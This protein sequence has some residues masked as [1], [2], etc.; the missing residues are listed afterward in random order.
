MVDSRLVAA[1]FGLQV[2]AIRNEKQGE[3]VSLELAVQ[4]ALAVRESFKAGR[5]KPLSWRIK[6]LNQLEKLLIENT[7]SI[8]AALHQDLGKSESESLLTE[9][10]VVLGEISLFRKSL[11]TW[12][13]PQKIKPGI[14]LWPA[15]AYT[16]FE[17]LGPICIISPW[18]YPLNLSLMPL[19][20]AIAAG[21]TAVIKPS[22][23]SAATAA[24]LEELIPQYLDQRAIRVVTGG[25]EI[26]QQLLTQPWGRIFYTGGEKVG[27]I[28]ATAAAQTLTPITLEL[29]GKSPVFVDESCNLKIAARRIVFGKFMNAGQTCVAPDYLLVSEKAY[30][31]LLQNLQVAIKKMYGADPLNN[32]NYGKIVSERHFTR[33]EETLGQALKMGAKLVY[34]GQ[35]DRQNRRIAP[36]IITDL[37]EQTRLMEEEIFGPILPIIKVTGARQA[38]DFINA[39]PQPLALYVFTANL[40]SWQAF[41]Y[42]T[43]SGALVRDMTVAQLSAP[44]LP[45]GGVGESGMG[46]YHGYR[47][48]QEFSHQK[49]VVEKSLRPDTLS[50]AYPPA[51]A[52]KNLILRHLLK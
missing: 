40:R 6:Q 18:N 26:T 21:N 49:S 10:N 4:G 12:L 20:G 22:E 38:I 46:A 52:L 51:T 48:L 42:Q 44:E 27:K 28:V 39:R 8:C 33:L 11:S 47:S 14:S 45:F 23:I 7:A 29:G 25:A 32:P 43:S 1:N 3:S 34:G 17:P 35:T 41:Q 31:E 13:K 2:I 36:A 16:I 30:S 9:I 24:L 5:S 37:P 19:V 50:L 15:K